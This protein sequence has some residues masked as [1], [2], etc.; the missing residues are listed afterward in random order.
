MM[1]FIL[2][3]EGRGMC[4]RRS[5]GDIVNRRKDRLGR[6]RA[7]CWGKLSMLWGWMGRSRAA[8][9]YGDQNHEPSI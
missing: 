6:R 5:M 8:V 9:L 1:I 2:D 3:G 7:G 4:I